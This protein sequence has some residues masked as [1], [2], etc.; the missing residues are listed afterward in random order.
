MVLT[1]ICLL[2]AHA[3]TT[4]DYEPPRVEWLGWS[5][6]YEYHDDPPYP[7][8]Q[9]FIGNLLDGDPTTA[10]MVGGVQVYSNEKE[11][12]VPD[13]E[14]DYVPILFVNLPK[15]MKIDGIRIMPGYNK[16][17]AVFARNNRITKIDI[18]D[19]EW[20]SYFDKDQPPIVAATLKDEMGWQTVTFA[21]REISGIQV[22][23][24]DWVKGKDNDFC[25][26][27]IQLLSDGKPVA[28]QVTPMV[29]S[30]FGS[31]CC[32][33]AWHVVQ[34]NGKIVREA[35]TN[36]FDFCSSDP[37]GRYVFSNALTQNYFQFYVLDMVKGEFIAHADRPRVT[38]WYVGYT[39]VE[40]RN[41][42]LTAK[43]DWDEQGARQ[44]Q[45]TITLRWATDP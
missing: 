20:S 24:K 4:L 3:G 41:G 16:S 8:H 6:G 33:A 28:W 42:G 44:K 7:A 19:S 11:A 5:V 29:L 21:Q 45:E 26:S 31:S 25:I 39:E 9:Y 32:G 34:R 1:A 37:T 12:F 10:W 30:T 2:T 23:I 14:P 35:G 27:D 22:V 36:E 13:F 40:W 43:I 17:P 38:G 18:H 15:A